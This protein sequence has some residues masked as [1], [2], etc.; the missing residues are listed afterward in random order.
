MGIQTSISSLFSFSPIPTLTSHPFPSLHVPLNPA[1]G[2]GALFY[3]VNYAS[4]VKSQLSFIYPH[5]S[6]WFS[7]LCLPTI[8]DEYECILTRRTQYDRLSQQQLGFVYSCPRLQ[9]KR[10]D[11]FRQTMDPVTSNDGAHAAAV[12]SSCSNWA[13]AAASDERMRRSQHSALIE[14][15]AASLSTVPHIVAS[16]LAHT[17]RRSAISVYVINLSIVHNCR[18]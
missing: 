10:P 12:C 14:V 17:L 16:R 4:E 11:G 7:F 2:F 3:F 5:L 9:A 6:V 13:D 8:Y 15:A 18:L 1:M